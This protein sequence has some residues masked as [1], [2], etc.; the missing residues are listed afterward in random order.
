[1]SADR[2]RILWVRDVAMIIAVLAFACMLGAMWLNHVAGPSGPSRKS[3]C[4]SNQRQVSMA[5]L[6]HVTTRGKG[7][8]PGFRKELNGDTISWTASLLSELGRGD[9]HDHLVRQGEVAPL[10]I[11]ILVCP[12][13]RDKSSSEAPLSYVINAGSAQD[14][15]TVL[16]NG[17]AVDGLKTEERVSLSYVAQNDGTAYTLLLA[18]NLQATRWDQPSRIG[19]TFLWHNTMT[20]REEHLINGGDTSLPV[21]LDTARPSSNHPG[22]A[23]FTFCDGHTKFI[24]QDIEY[25]VYAQLMSP[26]DRA[27]DMPDAW[28][29]QPLGE[30]DFLR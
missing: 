12:A 19:T 6:T 8:F 20:P 2:P 3:S 26:N 11:S 10:P 1:M 30:D 15:G 23:V 16:A 24:G 14:D 18:E 17:V 5:V 13:D 28:K 21:T 25:R 9:L 4:L 22:G 29:D 27:S 7:S